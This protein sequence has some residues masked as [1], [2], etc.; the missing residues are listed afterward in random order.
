M[1]SII[2][3]ITPAEDNIIPLMNI[4]LSI[5]DLSLKPSFLYSMYNLLI[6]TIEYNIKTN[7]TIKLW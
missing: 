2:E 3:I 7:I 5:L 4:D 6:S 1:K